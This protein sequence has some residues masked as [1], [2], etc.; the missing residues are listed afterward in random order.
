M[1]PALGTLFY[2]APEQADLT[3]TPDARW[4][5]YALGAVMYRMLTGE[6][7]HYAGARRCGRE[8]RSATRGVPQ[9]HPQLTEAG[10]TPQDPGR[11]R[12][13]RVDRRPLPGDRARPSGFPNPQAVLTALDAWQ[14]RRVR[15][16][17]LFLTG[18]AF[19]LLFLVMAIDRRVRLLHER[20]HG[21]A[22]S[23]ST[24]RSRATGSRPGP[25]RG[26]SA[27]RSSSAGRSSRPPP[28]T[29]IC[30]ICWRWATS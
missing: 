29:R 30:A 20:E 27:S 6:P 25:R 3:A 9:A 10:R 12:R 5:V 2:M 21:R 17:L 22:R 28:A 1:S 7:P 14:L 11:R 13:T 19:A 4:D 23:R 16:P 18:L 26:N 15:R 8:P 24:A